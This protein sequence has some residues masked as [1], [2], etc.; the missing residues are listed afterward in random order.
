MNIGAIRRESRGFLKE[1][2]GCVVVANPQG[3]ERSCERF[4]RGVF[5]FLSQ[6]GG[7]NQAERSKSNRRL[8]LVLVVDTGE[9]LT[10]F[11]MSANIGDTA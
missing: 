1:R 10:G 2:D 11:G 7:G 5:L 6:R 3:I 9:I 4:V 8:P